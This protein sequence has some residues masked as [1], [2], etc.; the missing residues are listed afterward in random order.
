[1]GQHSIELLG[2]LALFS[3]FL[4]VVEVTLWLS[5]YPSKTNCVICSSWI[6]TV[7]WYSLRIKKVSTLFFSGLFESKKLSLI[8]LERVESRLSNDTKFKLF[9]FFGSRRPEKSIFWKRWILVAKRNWTL[10]HFMQG[11]GFLYNTPAIK[12]PYNCTIA[13]MSTQLSQIMIQ[14]IFITK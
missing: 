2:N 1:M 13:M 8:S 7:L 6:T 3:A 12:I 5:L 10:G 9:F 14:P 4:S 11:W